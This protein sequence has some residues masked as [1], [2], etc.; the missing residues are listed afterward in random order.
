MTVSHM[1]PAYIADFGYCLL[2]K[3]PR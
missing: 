1:I 3:R 2:G